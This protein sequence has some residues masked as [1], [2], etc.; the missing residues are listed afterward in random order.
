VL[1]I[2]LSFFIIHFYGGAILDISAR[3]EGAIIKLN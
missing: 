3:V 1:A 2:L